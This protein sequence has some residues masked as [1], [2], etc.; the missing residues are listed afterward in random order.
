MKIEFEIP[1]AEIESAAKSAAAKAVME[2]VHRWTTNDDIAGKV[3]ALWGA[4]IDK[5][6]SEAL[7]NSDALKEKIAAAI[8]RKLKAKIDALM[9]KVEQ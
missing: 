8:E 3:R 5:Q 7:D 2:R 6:I 1:E 4:E 9:R